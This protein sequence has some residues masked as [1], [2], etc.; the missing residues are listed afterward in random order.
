[1]TKW[2]R[3]S[4]NV[5]FLLLKSLNFLDPTSETPGPIEGDQHALDSMASGQDLSRR[6]IRQLAGIGEDLNRNAKQGSI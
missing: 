2:V 6:S 1:V 5:S 4:F 3:R